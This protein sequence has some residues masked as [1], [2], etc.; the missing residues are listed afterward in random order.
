MTPDE[1]IAAQQ[2]RVPLSI[3]RAERKI[4]TVNPNP[5]VEWLIQAAGNCKNLRQRL[6][7]F[8]RAASAWASPMEPIAACRKGCCHCCFIPC[9]ILSEEAKL[10]ADLTGRTMVKPEIRFSVASRQDPNAPEPDPKRHLGEPCPFLKDG[11]C[12]VYENRPISCRTHYN[13][14][15]DSLLCEVVPD[16]PVTVPMINNHSI[17]GYIALQFPKDYL[18]DIRDFFPE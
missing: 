3:E 9:H 17:L 16:H 6:I 7:R 1:L 13:L 10:L 15:D 5:K 11:L 12:S 18:S 2:A 14:D 4:L 8:H